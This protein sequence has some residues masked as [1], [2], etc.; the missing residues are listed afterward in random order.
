MDDVRYEHGSRVA[1]YLHEVSGDTSWLDEEIGTVDD[2]GWHAFMNFDVET[3]RKV[4]ELGYEG[5][6]VVYGDGF[7]GA[8]GAMLYEDSQGFR[9]AHVF[10]DSTSYYDVWS[11][12]E[13]EMA[14]WESEVVDA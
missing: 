3:A 7:T 9:V 4:A 8:W 13:A 14:E 1:E 6:R 2:I 11:S 5:G 10:A 12:V